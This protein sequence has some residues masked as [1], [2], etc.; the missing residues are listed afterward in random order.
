MKKVID[1]LKE[2]SITVIATS[3]DNKPRASILEYAVID[4]CIILGTDNRSIKAH[5]LD[6]NPHISLSVQQLPKFVTIDG[7]VSTPTDEEIEEY[8]RRLIENHPEFKER[9]AAGMI[10]FT[11]YKVNIETAYLCDMSKG[12]GVE[13]IKAY[14]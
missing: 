12:P 6:S 4:D 7:A 8:M 2:N 3:S 14:V 1:F 10:Q 11:Y 5:N 13:I 9:M